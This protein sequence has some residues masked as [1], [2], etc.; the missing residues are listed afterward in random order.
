MY[1]GFFNK[2]TLPVAQPSKF[3]TVKAIAADSNAKDEIIDDNFLAV[4]DF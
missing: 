3:L 4:E 1:T 2:Y